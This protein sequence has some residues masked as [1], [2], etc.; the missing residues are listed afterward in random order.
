MPLRAIP[1][2]ES[3][4]QISAEGS[5]TIDRC[6]SDFRT[7]RVEGLYD[8]GVAYSTGSNGL[9]CDL[10]EAHKWF[11]IA[12]ILGHEASTW[13]RSDVAEEMTAREIANAQR[14]AREW[15]AANRRKAA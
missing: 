11:N 5:A 12:A 14:A 4:P 7:G 3:A 9:N 1:S 10:I 2:V 15:L 13:C 8:L 6:M